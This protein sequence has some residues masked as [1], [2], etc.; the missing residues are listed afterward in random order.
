M[1][2]LVVSDRRSRPGRPDDHQLAKAQE[3]SA[4]TP[5]RAGTESAVQH[6]EHRGRVADGVVGFFW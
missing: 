6:V 5:R 3:I 2:G 4:P 1:G